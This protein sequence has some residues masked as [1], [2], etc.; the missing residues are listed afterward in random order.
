MRSTPPVRFGGY[1]ARKAYENLRCY[2]TAA[3]S[4][5]T[6]V[7]LMYRRLLDIGVFSYCVDHPEALFVLATIQRTFRFN[8]LLPYNIKVRYISLIEKKTPII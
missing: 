1:L 3:Q 8:L 5:S 6:R 2:G 7:A 4:D